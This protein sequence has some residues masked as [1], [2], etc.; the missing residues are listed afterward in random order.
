VHAKM[1]LARAN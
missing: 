1:Q